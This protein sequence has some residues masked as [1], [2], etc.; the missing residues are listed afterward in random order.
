MCLSFLQGFYSND[1]SGF[2]QAN[3]LQDDADVMIQARLTQMQPSH[4]PNAADSHLKHQ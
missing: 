3:R 1:N 4:F 2:A